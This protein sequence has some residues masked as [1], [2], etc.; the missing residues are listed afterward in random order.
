MDDGELGVYALLS[1]SGF[2]KG[3][4]AKIVLVDFSGAQAPLI[5]LVLYL[6][7]FP[8]GVIGARPGV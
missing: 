2:P 3:Y 7:S 5:A 4:R 8:S 1:R 6:L